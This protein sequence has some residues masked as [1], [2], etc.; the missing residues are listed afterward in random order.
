M[1]AGSLLRLHTRGLHTMSYGSAWYA[2][3]FEFFAIAFGPCVRRG[4]MTPYQILGVNEDATRQEID[5]AY[6]ER[7]RRYSPESAVDA[8]AIQQVQAAYDALRFERSKVAR[9]PSRPRAKWRSGILG[10]LSILPLQL[11][12]WT[13]RKQIAV[14]VALAAL[15]LGLFSWSLFWRIVAVAC[16]AGL[17]GVAA[18]LVML[19][20]SDNRLRAQY[21]AG[22]FAAGGA[23]AFLCWLAIF[24]GGTSSI[25]ADN[26]EL[27]SPTIVVSIDERESGDLDLHGSSLIREAGGDFVRLY[28]NAHVV[29]LQEVAK[30]AVRQRDRTANITGF[31]MAV[32]F[33]SGKRKA[34]RRIALAAD[35]TLDVA[36]V[37]VSAEGLVAGK[38]YVVV[39]TVSRAL[40]TLHVK[41]GDAVVA[42]GTP[43]LLELANSPTYGRISSLRISRN[44]PA[45][46]KWIQ[47]DAT[48]AG[49]NSGGPLFLIRGNRAYWVGINTKGI[50]G[51]TMSFAIS[52]DDV[53]G[54]QLIWSNASPTGAA[55]LIEQVYGVPA[56]V[57]DQTPRTSYAKSP[58][59]RLQ[60]AE[61]S[62]RRPNDLFVVKQPNILATLFWPFSS[63]AP[64][65][66]L[67]A[68]FAWWVIYTVLSGVGKSWHR[69]TKSH[70]NGGDTSEPTVAS[71]E[72]KR[73]TGWGEEACPRCRQKSYTMYSV[74]RCP[75][76]GHSRESLRAADP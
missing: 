17:V 14:G 39:P 59:A 30:Q 76:C 3:R 31:S 34:A 21:V 70:G 24:A 10:A 29:G 51:T 35:A 47:H 45:S 65:L 53:A 75:Q 2:L 27:S 40:E 55:E 1:V 18:W 5:A 15:L 57:G 60:P 71:G 12:E 61:N 8:Q 66:N 41:S 54:A 20:K 48:I 32:Q 26:L 16:S 68:L 13:D 50:E 37:E 33:P 44:D 49:G 28:T 56:V 43:L 25:S 22:G 11:P 64:Y 67:R 58:P 9:Q 4:N 52:S 42:V 73:R 72:N 63:R 23:A 19:S 69:G 74:G 38:D 46:P 36:C 62:P 7:V 6:E